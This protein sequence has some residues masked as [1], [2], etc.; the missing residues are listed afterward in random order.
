MERRCAAALFLAAVRH[1]G[2]ARRGRFVTRLGAVLGAQER[3]T[4]TTG[5]VIFQRYLGFLC[6]VMM[7]LSVWICLRV[8][9]FTRRRVVCRLIL[10]R[11]FINDIMTS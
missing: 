6:D 2:R 4:A 11:G 8:L 1:Q 5:S 9:E 10:I 3:R 7:V